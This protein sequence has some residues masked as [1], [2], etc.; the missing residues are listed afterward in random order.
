[1][2]IGIMGSI[3]AEFLCIDYNDYKLDLLHQVKIANDGFC[4]FA[5]MEY[6]D[7]LLV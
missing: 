4:L 5:R 6:M 1:M 2:P 7:T 3:N